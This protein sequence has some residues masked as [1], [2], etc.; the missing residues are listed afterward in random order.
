MIDILAWVA[1]VGGLIA[2]AAA[3]YIHLPGGRERLERIFKVPALQGID[4][5]TLRKIAKPNQYLVLPAGF[6][7]ERPDVVAPVFNVPAERLAELWRT[8]TA[9]GPDVVERRWDAATL[10]AD[11][12]ER[13]S[14]MRYPDLVT[15]RFVA[16]DAARSTLAVY[17]RSVYG[18]GDRGVNRRRVSRWLDRL[19]KVVNGG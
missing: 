15:A 4:F 2:L 7:V 19:S 11:H 1:L 3:L 5:A 8:R 9:T 10:T 17:S 12:V 18:Y 16:V 13:T 6:G 14:L